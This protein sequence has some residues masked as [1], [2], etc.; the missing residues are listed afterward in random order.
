MKYSKYSRHPLSLALMTSV[1]AIATPAMAQDTASGAAATDLDKVTVTGSRIARTGFVTSSPVT[2]ISAEE[3]RSSGALNIGELM[4]KMPQ[5]SPSYSMGNSTRYIGTAG[6]GLMDLRGMGPSRTLVL[7]NGRRHVGASPG[8]SNVDVNTI[9]TEWIERVEVITGGASAVYGADAV[10]GVVNFIMK[11]S[12]EGMELRGQTGQASEG[13][14]DRS[15]VSFTAGNS[16]ADGRG[17]AAVAMEYSTQ[18]RFNRGDRAIG[19]E[20]LV[21]V[22]NPNFDSSKPASESNPQTVLSGPGGNHSISYGGT[23]NLGTIEYSRTGARSIPFEASSR[24]VFNPDGSVRR[25]RYDGTIV[26]ATSCTDCDFA[27]LNA[28]ADLQP[29]FDRFSFNTIANFDLNDNHRLFFEGKYSKTESNFYGQPSFDSSLRIRRDNAFISDDLAALMDNRVVK[30]AD[31]TT[32]AVSTDPNNR[33]SDLVM[34]RFNVDAGQRGELVERQ[35]SRVVAGIEGF[36]GDNWSYEASANFGQTTISRQN[37]NNR[38][39]DRFHA[40][41][42]AVI[43]PSSGQVVCRASL[44]P[45]AINPNT[46]VRYNSAL[47]SGC[48]P[49]SVFGDGSISPEAAAWFN[50]TALNSSKLQ[51]TVFSASAANGS[52]FSLPAGDVGIAFGVERREE[53]STENTDP[54]AALGLTFLNAIASRGGEYNVNEVFAETTVPLLSDIPGINRLALDLAARYSDYST[55]GGTTTWNVGLDWEI[56]S[57]LRFRG[58]VAQSVR[59]P[60]IGELFNP[61]S[62]NFASIADPCNTLVTNSNRPSTAKDPA[63]RAANCAALGIPSD[64]VDTYSSNRPGLSGGNPDLKTEEA[65]SVSLGFVWQPEFIEGF[66]MSVDYWRIT[67]DDA[68]GSVAAQTIATRCVDSPDGIDNK[69]CRMIDRAPEGGYT[70]PTGSAFPTHSIYNWSALNENL[71]KSRRVGVDLEMDYRFG[72][73]GGDANIRFVGTRMI[74]SREWAFQD[75]PDEF[76][77]YVT[78]VTDPRWRSQISAGYKLGQYRASWDMTYVDGN[79]RVTPASYNSNPGSASPIRNGSHTYHNLQLGYTFAD[80][81]VDV[82]MG[83]DNVFDKNPPRN[84]FGADQGSAYYDNIGRFIYM[85]ATYKF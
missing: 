18:G 26:S 23:T 3:I 41:L 80:T 15:F 27:D 5:L 56:I 34:G 62:Q 74:Q 53:K 50:S 20:Y 29:A 28:V 2:A 85:G 37:L 52:L 75:F 76:T 44:D 12:F 67:L 6:L 45:N 11:K 40:G 83:V 35:T 17:N 36:F 69:F 21:S 10:A 22:P 8:S 82:Y 39:N 7:V 13:G 79:L 68:I 71:A 4:N 59:A 19:R 1:A 25:N 47:V 81:G 77:E 30:L 61:Q 24:Y 51:Q 48:I 70:S 33:E 9:P 32:R 58:T 64:W 73:A 78:Y 46:G 42:D 66:G 38:I 63:L 84:Y 65:K 60:S 55:I 43:D 54:L 16:F 14:F 31:G 57:S 72:L 49:F